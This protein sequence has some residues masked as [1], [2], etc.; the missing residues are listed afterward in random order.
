MVAMV[1]SDSSGSRSPMPVVAAAYIAATPCALPTPPAEPWPRRRSFA[2]L[3]RAMTSAA[4]K[5]RA[6]RL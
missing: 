1:S 5:P 6:L 2:S 4:V 3:G